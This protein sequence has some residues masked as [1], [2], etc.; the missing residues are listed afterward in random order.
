LFTILQSRP[1]ASAACRKARLSR[2]TWSKGPRAGRRRT[3]RF[4]R[5]RASG[6]GMAANRPPFLLT[7]P[8]LHSAILS[9][10]SV[11][12]PKRCQPVLLG[13]RRNSEA[14][15]ELE[16]IL[17]TQPNGPFCF[18]SPKLAGRSSV[19][20]PAMNSRS[21]TPMPLKG[22]SR[23][24][25]AVSGRPLEEKANNLV[26]AGIPASCRLVVNPQHA[27]ACHSLQAHSLVLETA[28]SFRLA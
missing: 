3:Y 9:G 17:R 11:V 23:F 22:Q 12:W 26:Q 21:I 1:M 19:A 7:A 18:G 15:T 28:S 20:Q 25:L 16:T 10:T 2:S 24:R 27:T 14:V 13:L 4:C 8:R 6:L 5:S